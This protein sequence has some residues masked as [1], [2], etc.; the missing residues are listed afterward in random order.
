MAGWI[1]YFV[2]I[3]ASFACIGDYSCGFRGVPACLIIIIIIIIIFYPCHIYT[4][5]TDVYVSQVLVLLVYFAPQHVRTT[6][7]LY[8]TVYI[9]M[10]KPYIQSATIASIML[11]E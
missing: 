10:Y 7:S 6:R 2:C 11:I 5:R 3:A 1:T 4:T 8:C 9:R